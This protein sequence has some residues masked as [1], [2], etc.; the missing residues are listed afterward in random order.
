MAYRYKTKTIKNT[1]LLSTALVLTG[2]AGMY[3]AFAQSSDDEAIEEII[4]TGSHIRRSGFETRSPIQVLNRD[5]IIE[6]GAATLIDVVKYLPANTG[7]FITQETGNL[8]GTSQFNIRGL[9]TGSTLTL[10]NG[11]RA[12]KS[13]TSD[14][15]GNQFF[16]INQLPLSMISRV[17]MQTD[18]AS[19]TYG[20]EA[21]AGVANIITRKGFEGLELS[22]RASTASNDQWNVSLASGAKTDRGSVN[23]YASFYRQTRNDRSDFNWVRTRVGDLK[24]GFPGMTS[25]T[26][27]PGTYELA[28]VDA[29][30]N[31][32]SKSGS[33]VADPD[34]EAAGG[35][36]SGGRCRLSFMD[37]VSIIPE[38]SR[39]QA[40]AEVEYALS[41]NMQFY[42]ELSFSHNI[43][44]RTQGPNLFRNGVAR[45]NMLVSGDHP[46]NFFVSDGSD[47]I[48]YIGPEDWDNDIHTGVALY[49]SCRPLGAEFM[50]DGSEFDTVFTYDYYRALAGIK[51]DINQ[52]WY[53]DVSYVYNKSDRNLT[54]AYSYNASVLNA[55]L[56]AGTFNPFG[57]R[58]TNPT[59][60]SPKDG[61]SVAG[62]NQD[63]FNSWHHR[64]K[65]DAT[66]EQVAVDAVISGDVMELPG[67]AL[68]LAFG[69]QYRNE[70]FIQ[71]NDSLIASGLASTPDTFSSLVEGEVDIYA[72]FAEALLPISEDLEVSVAARHESFGGGVAT[73]DPKVSARWQ[74]A[75]VVALRASYGTSFQAPSVSQKSNSTSSQF[76]DDPASYNGSGNLTCEASGTASNVSI[77]VAGSNDLKPQT[78][79]NF[80]GGLVFNNN[81]LQISA[82]YWR[83]DYSG[84]IR[85]DGE[86]QAIVDADCDDG[87]LNDPR[88]VRSPSGQ[89]RSV[90]LSFINTGKVITDGLDLQIGYQFTEGDL[91]IVGLKAA[92]SYVNK[93]EVNLDGGTKFDGAGNRNFTNPFS[94]V[95]RIRGNMQVQWHLNQHSAQTALRYISSYDNDQGS[96]SPEIAAWTSV[97][98]RY[99]YAFEN[100]SSVD[101]AV[102]SVGVNNAFDKL[103]PALATAQRPGY[104][105][106]V[107][108]IR[109]R[110]LYAEL[111]L[112]F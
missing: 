63:D 76:L 30:G 32:S 62:L 105:A 88:I 33:R 23:F 36:L 85:P 101:R 99:S 111:S 82:D 35:L 24:E 61:V 19:V 75:E 46:F 96:D 89:I 112:S 27:A 47:G 39:I 9:G 106:T 104:D 52:N 80:N 97:D 20:S 29:E 2:Y 18:G 90:A 58:V 79:K 53:A 72:A 69:G 26:G 3:D 107:H 78:S 41:D 25:G 38:E 15:N 31:Y 10:I 66:A 91:G 43:V 84:L 102:F 28:Q 49:C 50:G 110:L 108:D 73:S 7:S 87:V 21:V 57:T 16:D 103:P 100:I 68:G 109:G 13:A 77:D 83:F 92:L 81:G 11:R 51:Y 86:A 14:G 95:P 65:F 4:V 34:C 54:T 44:S 60:I 74:V 71:I 12:G 56:A 59:L 6:Q 94:S 42:S 5:D 1:L 55:S 70:T 17:D 37:Q 64:G 8:T 40:F 98:L 93:F 67:G 48:T 45:G 22:A